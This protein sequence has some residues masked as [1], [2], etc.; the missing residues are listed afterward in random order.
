L[1][2]SR[3][4]RLLIGGWR[5]QL[6]RALC[7]VL[8]VNFVGGPAAILRA[9]ED[10]PTDC[11]DEFGSGEEEMDYVEEPGTDSGAP[12]PSDV[13]N[14]VD[15]PFVNVSG[16][17]DPIIDPENEPDPPPEPTPTP[18]APA[19]EPPPVAPEPTPETPPVEAVPESSLP[20]P[21]TETPPD[22]TPPE[23]SVA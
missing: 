13:L 3:R 14:G 22:A 5:A 1:T 17:T 18:V 11:Q 8:L 15:D 9:C 7:L 4:D 23:T 12:A 20:D 2:V 6:T 21:T 19:I 10:D 16:G